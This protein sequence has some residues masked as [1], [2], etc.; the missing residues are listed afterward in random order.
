MVWAICCLILLPQAEAQE[1]WNG[2]VDTE[3]YDEEEDTFELYNA[4]QLAGLAVLV[5]QGETFSGKTI[6]LMDDIKLNEDGST[7]N[8]WI[9]V[10]G[11]ANAGTVQDPNSIFFQGRFNG[12]HHRIWNLYCEKTNYYQAGLFG[13]V[14]GDGTTIENLALINPVVIAKGMAGALIGYV[15]IGNVTINNCMVVDADIRIGKRSEN[16]YA[17][18]LIGSTQRNTSNTYVNNCGLTGKI[19]GNQCG[20]M[21]GHGNGIIAVNCY[22]LGEIDT[23]G[24]SRPGMKGGLTA[25]GGESFTNCYSTISAPVQGNAGILKTW[26]DIRSEEFVNMLGSNIFSYN[27]CISGNG[28]PVLSW[29]KLCVP[30]TGRTSICNG[31]TTDITVSGFDQ[32]I[33]S[34]GSTSANLRETPAQTTVYTVIASIA[35]GIS[36]I[37]DITVDVSPLSVTTISVLPS[38]DDSIHARIIPDISEQ[39]CMNTSPI[40]FKIVPD[41]GFYVSGILANGVEIENIDGAYRDTIPFIF[42][43][44]G[45]VWD[46]V[47]SMDNRFYITTELFVEE[48]NVLTE[49]RNNSSL[50]EPWGNDGIVAVQYNTDTI[51]QIK[52]SQRYELVEVILN[53]S[54]LGT[55]GNIIF[56]NVRAN[57]QVK[58]IYRDICFQDT[59]PY[60]QGFADMSNGTFPE[61]W[62]R[63]NTK[64][65]P[66]NYP[67]VSSSPA[68]TTPNSL[69]FSSVSPLE[70]TM[71]IT[72]R[73][74]TNLSALYTSYA[75]RVSGSTNAVM[76]VGLISDPF[77]GETFIPFQTINFNDKN[78]NTWYE[79]TTDFTG[80]NGDAHYIAFK[81]VKGYFYLDDVFIDILP[82]CF[83]VMHLAVDE[84]S[85]S[86]VKISWGTNREMP[87]NGYELSWQKEGDEN[88]NSETV[89]GYHHILKNLED[90]TTYQVKV[91]ADCGSGTSEVRTITFT[92]EPCTYNGP[93]INPE[94]PENQTG[95]L[96]VAGN[97]SYTQQIYLAGELE[98]TAYD[99]EYIGFRYIGTSGINHNIEIFLGHTTETIF[100]DDNNFIP[101][102]TLKRVYTG[103]QS[104]DNT[105]KDNWIWIK[106]DSV[107]TYNGTSNLVLAFNDLQGRSYNTSSVRFANHNTD[108]ERSVY[109]YGWDNA[110]DK[111]N[112][113]SHDDVTGGFLNARNN[114]RFR[115]CGSRD[116]MPVTHID[117]QNITAD[118][119]TVYWEQEGLATAY[120]ME[121]KK[122]GDAGWTLVEETIHDH[123]YIFTGLDPDM[124]YHIRIKPVCDESALLEWGTASF[125]TGCGMITSIPYTE[126]F[127][128][129]PGALFPACWH[130]LAEPSFNEPYIQEDKT[131]NFSLLDTGGYAMAILPEMSNTILMEDLQVNIWARSQNLREGYFIFG[132]I[133]QPSEEGIFIPLDTL[134]PS[135]DWGFE[136]MNITLFEYP[137][138]DYLGRYLAFRWENGLYSPLLNK[139]EIVERERCARPENFTVTGVGS[140][141]A[142]IQWNETGT[143]TQWIVEYDFA[144]F[145]PGS[146][147]HKEMVDEQTMVLRDLEPNRHYEVYV[148]AYC[149][150]GDTS[151]WRLNDFTTK[152]GMIPNDAL[153]HTEP[154]ETYGSGVQS[155]YPDCWTRFSSYG[156]NPYIVPEGITDN[157]VLQFNAS[158]G[159]KTYGIMPSFATSVDSLQLNFKYRLRTVSVPLVIGIMTHNED[160]STFEPVDTIYNTTSDWEEKEI[161]LINYRGDGKFIAF[162]LETASTVW[163]DDIVVSRYVSCPPPA[164]LVSTGV[165]DTSLS[166]T[167]TAGRSESDWEIEIGVTGFD[168]GNGRRISTNTNSYTVQGLDPSTDYDLYYRAVCSQEDSS[169][170]AGPVTLFTICSPVNIP[171]NENFDS[172]DASAG[173]PGCWMAFA[174]EENALPFISGAPEES[175]PSAPNG[176]VLT[177]TENGYSMVVLPGLDPVYPT[178]TLKLSFELKTA[179]LNNGYLIIGLLN[180]PNNIESF[181]ALDTANMEFANQWD[182]LE[183]NFTD[184]QQLNGQFIS[185]KYMGGAGNSYFI[186]NVSIGFV[187]S[188]CMTPHSL[189]IAHDSQEEIT[190]SW[191][192]GAEETKWLFEYKIADSP[193][194][195]TAEVCTVTYKQITGLNPETAY[196]IRISAICSP[197]LSSD[198][199][200]T[201]ITTST[202]G[203]TDPEWNKII[204]V[205]PNPAE[206]ILHVDLNGLENAFEKWVISNMLGQEIKSNTITGSYFQLNISSLVPGL[207]F[208][209]LEGN[210]GILTRKFIKQ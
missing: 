177:G 21:A 52:S 69:Y 109:F 189:I 179:Q 23:D 49:I 181:L 70:Y 115:F 66:D 122:E 146:G 108:G 75:L 111:T 151:Q 118:G 6:N 1:V 22:F 51:Y 99:I 53:G 91:S 165:T 73:L 131:M 44:E 76:Q 62:W 88:W 59:F 94:N 161:P 186:D 209:R 71:A 50:V 191:S 82:E 90:S 162:L 14:K 200:D 152:C 8:N 175:F 72:P 203:I 55:P 123:R 157:N 147:S 105:G 34:N 12:N 106:L 46:L 120:N 117:F 149:S 38:Y 204:S 107:F 54:S 166:A 173:L 79:F 167:W 83:P 140:D 208:I 142:Q 198:Y 41:T 156:L 103:M 60:K 158:S 114:I 174:S 119:A 63:I 182:S 84:K 139:I 144:G 68:Y 87:D 43:P 113:Y 24:A 47:V 39:P 35:D 125:R 15:D 18:A 180:D 135:T 67:S 164:N 194:E 184:Y 31:Q 77:D 95:R 205:Y 143:A 57:Q 101:F 206:N 178:D 93:E 169:I 86:S 136:E 132:I 170:W 16:N 61:C 190:V 153:P 20:G 150:E 85:A 128:S 197:D 19:A 134:R 145:I 192:A 13:A 96:P 78:P 17:G 42:D 56:Q 160:I 148:S 127:T 104:F 163:I 129:Y 4:G 210:E 126:D 30:Y 201:V 58:V 80:Y 89:H 195:Y 138:I 185:I 65:T 40:T 176:L 133:D 10:G 187:E 37:E 141:T 97:Y 36:V 137:M 155:N 102:N 5:N 100:D 124:V 121:Y 26:E 199:L 116:C 92:T 188:V 168:L 196:D 193:L 25:D 9:P 11:N 27:P 64:A 171:Y 183:M 33:W 28:A 112:P 207:Y 172:R 159:D 130:S 81:C 110:I 7:D 45:T 98:S 32:Y 202:I 3:W 2:S 29:L 154:F 48:E 74:D